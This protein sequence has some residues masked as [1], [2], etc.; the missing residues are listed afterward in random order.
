MCWIKA[1]RG[2]K[3]Q[4]RSSVLATG[5]IASSWLQV[6][7]TRSEETL[8]YL[9]PHYSWLKAVYG[10]PH[11]IPDVLL[12]FMMVPWLEIYC[13]QL[14]LQLLSGRPDSW[15]CLLFRGSSL[16]S[17]RWLESDWL[18]G[19]SLKGILPFCADVSVHWC[20]K[21]Y[22]VRWWCQR[23]LTIHYIVLPFRLDV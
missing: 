7:C 18:P 15:F 22:S 14:F 6:F 13:G 4:T 21:R 17:R 8:H 10:W 19:K 23:T 2:R 11:T 3:T 1:E 9:F 12:T 5:E 16:A 20:F